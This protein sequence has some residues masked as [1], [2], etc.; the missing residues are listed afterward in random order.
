MVLKCD[1]TATCAVNFDSANDVCFS[2]VFNS[3]FVYVCCCAF[4]CFLYF[5]VIAFFERFECS[6]FL[7]QYIF[8]V[9]SAAVK[10]LFDDRIL[11]KSLA[12]VLQNLLSTFRNLRFF[13]NFMKSPLNGTSSFTCSRRLVLFKANASPVLRVSVGPV[14]QG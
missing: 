2:C 14:N 11:L 5:D 3:F 13:T 4:I 12:S 8:Q 7:R 1:E 10:V 9:L 6:S